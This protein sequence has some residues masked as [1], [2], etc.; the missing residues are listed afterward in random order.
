MGLNLSTDRRNGPLIQT[1]SGPHKQTAGKTC[2]Q[3]TTPET[4]DFDEDFVDATIDSM[5]TNMDRPEQF[6]YKFSQLSDTNTMTYDMAL[7]KIRKD[8]PIN[9][10]LGQFK[11]FFTE[12][13]F[14]TKYSHD[15][16]KILYVGAAEGWH[17][18]KLADLFPNLQFDL[19]DPRYFNL[20]PRTNIKIY[21]RLF[22]NADATNYSESGDKILMMC[23][24]RTLDIGKLKR[25]HKTAQMDE[26]VMDD[27]E[28]QAGWVKIINPVYVYLKFRLH[29]F[30]DYKLKYFPGTIY[31]QPYSPAS[32]EVRLMT[33][34]YL[35]MVEYDSKEHDEKISYFNV[36]IK[37]NCYSRWDNVLKKYNLY[38]CWD[39]TYALYIVDYFL[40]KVR[41]TRSDD[42]TGNLFMDILNYHVKKYGKKYDVLFV[43]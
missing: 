22:T 7:E 40:R 21:K 38:N 11:L 9:M 25:D 34:N 6:I 16:T 27:M 2:V 15:A 39:T 36:E 32:S 37:P 23:D 18:S 24:I 42:K 13:L 20:E 14:L 41:G 30:D 3:I 43:A 29:W 4:M 8:K 33:N 31:L 5:N 1:K 26:L 17:I 19:W 12:L 28:M 35:D 10:H